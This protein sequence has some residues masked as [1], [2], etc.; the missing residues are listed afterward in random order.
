MQLITVLPGNAKESLD[1]QVLSG[2]S[3]QERVPLPVTCL[4]YRFLRAFGLK[5]SLFRLVLRMN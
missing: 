5:F 3:Q 4:G 2:S 1:K